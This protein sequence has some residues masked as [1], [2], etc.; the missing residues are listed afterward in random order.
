MNYNVEI[1]HAN[2]MRLEV[3]DLQLITDGSFTFDASN[4]EDFIL[5][6]QNNYTFL[7]ISEILSISSNDI[8]YVSI[9]KAQP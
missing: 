3:K 1:K 8:Q 5:Q 7:G 9:L 2:G 6:K 4:F